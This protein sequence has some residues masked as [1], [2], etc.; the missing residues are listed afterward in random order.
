MSSNHETI[1]RQWQMLRFIPRYPGK[2]TARELNEKLDAEDFIVSK[3]T[4]ERDLMDLSS[5]F[6]LTLDDRNRPFGWSWQKDAP[7]FDLPGLG[8]NEA[9]TM[10]MVEQH[11]N[12]L[13]PAT[14]MQVLEPYFKAARQ[15]LIAIPKAQHM[16]SWLNKVRTVPPN[17]PLLSPKIN[18][19]V[20]HTVSE[21][22]LMD[23]QLQII[24]RRRG[25][26]KTAEYRIHPLALIQR[27]GLVYLS[28]RIHDYYDTRIL[29]LHRIESATLLNE[30]SQYPVGFDIDNEIAKGLFGFGDSTMIQLKVRFTHDC[31]NHLFETP[32]SSD[33]K[34]RELTDGNLMLTATVANTPQLR[35]WLLGL[36]DGAEVIEPQK[37]R[38]DMRNYIQQ[39]AKIY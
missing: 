10:M 16:H 17:Q 12:A 8:N 32:L 20:H 7:A 29:A 31:G 28:V 39:M 25:D 1:L 24:Y 38:D 2:I 33:Q 23:R 35:W 13:L 4:I 6:P 19:A 22:L 15:H 26:T 5:T 36:A 14:T 18:P 27:G 34:I 21:G 30:L 11:L 37:L 3:R 9:L